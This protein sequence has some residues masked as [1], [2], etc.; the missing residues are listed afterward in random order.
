MDQFTKYAKIIPF[1]NTYIA[2]Q[3]GFVLL[4]RLIWYHGIPKIIISN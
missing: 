4:D 3:L 1:S 2:K